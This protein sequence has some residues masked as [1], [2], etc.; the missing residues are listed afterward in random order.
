MKT[1]TVH[2]PN[3]KLMNAD[4]VWEDAQTIA[5]VLRKNLLKADA[6]TRLRIPLSVFLLAMDS[7]DRNELLVLQ[8]RVQEKLAA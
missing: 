2:E 5:A 4:E 8:E 1:R 7:L 6:E 3:A